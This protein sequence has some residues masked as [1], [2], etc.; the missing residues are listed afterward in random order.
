M[1]TGAAEPYS[2]SWTVL[3]LCDDAQGFFQPKAG[4]LLGLSSELGW[5]SGNKNLKAR[6][7][8][9]FKR[10]FRWPAALC[11]SKS[12]HSCWCQGDLDALLASPLLQIPYVKTKGVQARGVCLSLSLSLFRPGAEEG[13]GGGSSS[14]SG[15]RVKVKGRGPRVSHA[16]AALEGKGWRGTEACTGAIARWPPRGQDSAGV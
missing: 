13:N 5:L 16:A 1:P 12:S 6:K 8:D 10:W 11:L 14:P 15:C 7:G 9:L 3:Q 4:W 2:C